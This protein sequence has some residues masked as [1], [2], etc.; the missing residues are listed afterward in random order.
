MV[1]IT[2][3]NQTIYTAHYPLKEVSGIH[4]AGI[5][6]Q[7]YEDIPPDKAMCK[8]CRDDYYNTHQPQGCWRFNNSIVCD[9]VGHTSINVAYG[10]DGIMKKTLSCWH[11]V[12]K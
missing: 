2:V 7:E 11:A 4:G 10:P 3:G 8:G 5:I 1:H 6:V 12:R 9:K